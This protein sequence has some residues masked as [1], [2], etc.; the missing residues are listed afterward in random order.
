MAKN[1]L[2]EYSSCLLFSRFES[3]EEYMNF[4]NEFVERE[5]DSARNFITQISVSVKRVEN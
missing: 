4:M 5:A 1:E 2:F 3:K